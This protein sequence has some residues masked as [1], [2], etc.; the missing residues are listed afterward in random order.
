VGKVGKVRSGGR[1]VKKMK[2][3]THK[4]DNTVDKWV[5]YNANETKK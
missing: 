2:N 4:T 3:G 5:D 1:K